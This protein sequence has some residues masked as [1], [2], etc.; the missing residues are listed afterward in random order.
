MS[1]G[2]VKVIYCV[3]VFSI[4]LILI[5]SADVIGIVTAAIILVGAKPMF[6]AVCDGTARRIIDD[7]EGE[8]EAHQAPFPVATYPP[9]DG[10]LLE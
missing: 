3:A 1:L 8:D 9:D 4:A 5:C 7:A 2:H 10:A 6:R